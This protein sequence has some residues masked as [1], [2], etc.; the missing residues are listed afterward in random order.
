M[1]TKNSYLSIAG[2]LFLIIA[3]K[4]STDKSKMPDEKSC[5]VISSVIQDTTIMNCNYIVSRDIDVFPTEQE[6]VLIQK[7]EAFNSD[8]IKYDK[9]LAEKN[10]SFEIVAECVN[11]K[12]I[13]S[14]EE[15]DSLMKK[16]RKKFWEE[17]Q[18]KYGQQ[19][20]LCSISKPLFS[21]NGQFAVVRLNKYGGFNIGQSKIIILRNT[22]SR[23]I[24]H[25]IIENWES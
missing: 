25:E 9:D 24:L 10:A 19:S 18:L 22:G 2:M 15:I 13:I 17:F 5:S 11:D 3:C 20:T 8:E 16:D 7:N 23:W 4:E 21:I 6:V 12:T 14:F 1:K